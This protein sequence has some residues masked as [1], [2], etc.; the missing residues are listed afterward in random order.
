MIAND[1]S[2][3]HDPTTSVDVV[4]KVFVTLSQKMRECLIC[5]GVFTRQGSAEH[6]TTVCCPHL[7]KRALFT[8]FLDLA[9]AL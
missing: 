2:S 5:G 4:G 8:D 6:A 9:E 3:R 1:H 7:G